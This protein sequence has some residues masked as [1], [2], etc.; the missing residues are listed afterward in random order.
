MELS[1]WLVIN[2]KRQAKI[3]KNKPNLN[4][5][6][7]A[8]KLN[9]NVPDSL[10]KKP[11]IEANIKLNGEYN[12]KLDF[13]VENDLKDLIETNENLHLVSINIEKPETKENE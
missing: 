3:Y 11:L 1:N 6:E 4:Y 13:E 5:N 12:Q 7:V 10:F 9:V 8:I 2:N